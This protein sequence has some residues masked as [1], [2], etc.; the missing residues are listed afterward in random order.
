MDTARRLLD[1]GDEPDGKVFPRDGWTI[2]PLIV[3]LEQGADDC[4]RVLLEAG[5]NPNTVCEDFGCSPAPQARC[6]PLLLAEV[7]CNIPAKRLLLNYGADPLL[8]RQLGISPRT[9]RPARNLR[10]SYLVSGIHVRRMIREGRPRREIE[11][12]LSRVRDLDEDDGA[13]L[14]EACR[15]HSSDVVELFVAHGA[16]PNCSWPISLSDIDEGNGRIPRILLQAGYIA[17]TRALVEA[18]A[19]GSHKIVSLLLDFGADPNVA[20]PNQDGEWMPTP[21]IAAILH[22]QVE[23]LSVLLARGAHP[24]LGIDG[25]PEP[26]NFDLEYPNPIKHWYEGDRSASA[27]NHTMCTPLMIACGTDNER[28]TQLLLQHGATVR[29]TNSQG[30]TASDYAHLI[31]NPEKRDRMLSL[32]AASCRAG[33]E[34]PIF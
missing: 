6:T 25:F 21:L 2:T 29:V 4:V 5:A 9:F 19:E 30:K 24:D 15:C 33:I 12:A 20:P 18:T 22:E 8:A 3:A 23:C 26:D 1:A 7:T 28:S 17:D 34:P 31:Q 27:R 14:R 10:A 13:L 16:N 32:L 11:R